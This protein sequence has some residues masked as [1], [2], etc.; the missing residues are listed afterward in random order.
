MFRLRFGLHLAILMA[1][2]LLVAL[3]TPVAAASESGTAGRVNLTLTCSGSA[4]TGRAEG[5]AG[6]ESFSL[7]CTPGAPL[8]IS[9]PELIGDPNIMPWAVNLTETDARGS[10]TTCTERGTG[11]PATLVCRGIGDPEDFVTIAM[12]SPPR[13]E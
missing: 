8:G 12:Q 4:T 6:R 1:Q 13:P 3:L 10:T 11:L 7:A 9:N 5:T 2:C